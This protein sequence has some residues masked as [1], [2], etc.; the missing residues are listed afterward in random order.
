MSSL[1]M[2]ALFYA[3]APTVAKQSPADEAR[4]KINRDSRI[5]KTVR[6]NRSQSV[7]PAFYSYMV[8]NPKQVIER[9]LFG[10]HPKT[11]RSLAEEAESGDDNSL[12]SWIREG[13]NPNEIDRYGYTPLLNA[14]V[15]GR[16]NAAS[17]LIKNGADV[18]K[19]GPF[20]FTPLH[21]AAQ[22][23]HREVVALLLKNNADINAQNDDL[24]TPMHLAIRAVRIEIVYMLVRCGGNTRIE[25]FNHKDCI[26]TAKEIGLKDMANSLK[27]YNITIGFHPHSAPE[28]IKSK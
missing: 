11:K 1:G 6:L 16:F 10:I 7:T 19:K 20:G 3:V 14:C 8:S 26:Q 25:G 5:N 24:D 21:A 27:N 17:E 22:N 23:G 12:S 15:L 9:Y 13:V 18:N 4:D 28:M 2:C